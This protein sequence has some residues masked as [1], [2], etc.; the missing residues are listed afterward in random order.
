MQTV[1]ATPVTSKTNVA[2]GIAVGTAAAAAVV[3][4]Q[5]LGFALFHKISEKVGLI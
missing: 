1:N 4:V 2:A 5:T 3:V